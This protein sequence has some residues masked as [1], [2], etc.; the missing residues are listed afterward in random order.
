MRCAVKGIHDDPPV[1]VYRDLYH[2]LRMLASM[3]VDA[4]A[5]ICWFP[6]DRAVSKSV[7]GLALFSAGR[8]HGAGE[9]YAI[10]WI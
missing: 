4:M 10:R 2:V 3:P 9:T 7:L 1:N 5:G 8:T 6:V